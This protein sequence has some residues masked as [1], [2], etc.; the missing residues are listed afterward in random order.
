MAS[1]FLLLFK[2]LFF[3][4]LLVMQLLMSLL[5]TSFATSLF[6][7][8]T[9][10]LGGIFFMLDLLLVSCPFKLLSISDCNEDFSLRSGWSFG[11]PCE[12]SKQLPLQDV[13]HNL[14]SHKPKKM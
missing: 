3:L 6:F 5:P 8:E 12:E 2:L 9:E 11:A 7:F 4:C 1:D 14:K 13:K 10:E